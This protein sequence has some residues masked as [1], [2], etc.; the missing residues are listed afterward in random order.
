MYFSK[1]I[2]GRGDKLWYTNFIISITLKYVFRYYIEWGEI[3][4]KKLY[5]EISVRIKHI[6]KY[7]TL[8]IYKIFLNL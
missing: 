8:E 5:F 4:L 7:K 2:K 1:I 3:L 6:N